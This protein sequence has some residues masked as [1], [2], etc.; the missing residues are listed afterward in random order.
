MG[1]GLKLTI[2]ISKNTTLSL[3]STQV[4]KSFD[5]KWQSPNILF[6]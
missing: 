6:P 5:N 1:V 2:S 3:C 4:D